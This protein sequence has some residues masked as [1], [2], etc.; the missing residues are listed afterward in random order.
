MRGWIQKSCVW[1]SRLRQLRKRQQNTSLGAAAG[2]L[3]QVHVSSLYAVGPR[4]AHLCRK[5]LR[6]FKPSEFA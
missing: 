4:R 3:D 1:S 2:F 5:V 6:T